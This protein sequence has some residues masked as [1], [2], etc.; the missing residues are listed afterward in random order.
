MT[1]LATDGNRRE[2]SLGR[3]FITPFERRSLAYAPF[4]ASMLVFLGIAIFTGSFWLFNEYQKFQ[5][6]ITNIRSTYNEM[7]RSRVL[8]E[9]NKVE[10]LLEDRLSKVEIQTENELRD[11]V[12]SAYT[13]ASHVFRMYRDEKEIPELRAMVVELLR[14][15]RWNNGSGYYLAGR[16]N[17]DRID[18]FADD[19]FL[20]G[21]P[22]S[23]LV[24]A[25]GHS[26]TPD[27]LDIVRQEKAGI[28]RSNLLKQNFPA[29]RFPTVFF[30]KYFAPFDWYIGAA[31]SSEGLEET[32]KK[33]ILASLSTI[34]FGEDGHVF[35]FRSDGTIIGHRRQELVGRSVTD[36]GNGKDR[37]GEKMLAFARKDEDGFIRYSANSSDGSMEQRVAFLRKYPAWNWTIVADMSMEAME[38]AVQHETITY[39][40]ISFKNVSVF[41][42]LFAIA[43]LSLLGMA[44]YHSVKIKSGI[45][46]F[47]DFFRKA[48]GVKAKIPDQEMS[49][50]EFENLAKLANKMVDE[51]IQKER[52]VH[53]DELRLDTLL[54]LGM[55]EEY[56]TAR[57]YDFVLD[58][59]IQITDSEEGYI[60]LVN[61]RQTELT[62]YS[63]VLSSSDISRW[64]FLNNT[65][66]PIS[67]DKA[68]LLKECVLHKKAYITSPKKAA[69]CSCYPYERKIDCRIDVPIGDP[70]KV[71]L[72]AGVCNSSQG[73]DNGDI[74]QMTMM[75]EGLW[76]NIL[77]T[78]S[79]Q[80]KAVLERQ[81]I[82]A[83]EEERTRIG[84][85][86]HDDL[87]A[88]L[89]GIE[90]LAKVLQKKVALF[91]PDEAGRVTII[92]ELIREAIDKTR[93]L[94]RG[95]YPVH[96]LE[97]GL[98]FAIEELFAEIGSIYSVDCKLSFNCKVADM[99]DN[100]V[101]NVY[102]IVREASFNA[103]R[104]G[105][106]KT[107][108]VIIV[109]RNNKLSVSVIDDG[110]G[111]LIQ[112]S[113][114]SGLGLHTMSYRAKAIGAT[115]DIQPAENGGTIVVLSGEIFI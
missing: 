79:E 24:D 62:L 59:I 28:Y 55:M 71:A 30:V 63:R 90:L 64:D 48:I 87:G 40:N 51:L 15:I 82:A 102:Y 50:V 86:L 38:K 94:S 101:T 113:K 111:F 37:Y 16:L 58:R 34:K 114:K 67:L 36:L 109:C 57:K 32:L 43:A 12:Q 107:I 35:C 13:I 115:L 105:K 70:G 93:R 47:T 91:S 100:V 3:R 27:L 5:A 20:E 4:H 66:E 75:L 73:Y 96:V 10:L 33:E 39:K 103:A 68:G 92:R 53:I 108:R 89:S 22:L 65:P 78:N 81:V 99:S 74:R 18:L 80:E 17:D 85:D 6:S 49:F 52:V 98:E 31:S 19:P 95:L 106:A 23:A 21:K 110:C 72:V 26:V 69:A 45:D 112:K 88:H 9:L 44:Y 76:L 7:N 83:G 61:D 2:N 104:H 25:S 42:I 46:L 41:I 56:D 77:K 1:N 54:Q 29:Q 60:A 11:K 84:R 14:P 97:H 8:E